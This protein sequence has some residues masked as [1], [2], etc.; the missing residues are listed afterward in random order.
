MN[1]A[2]RRESI[3]S[4]LALAAI[5][6][7]AVVLAATAPPRSIA[8]AC[9]PDRSA[10]PSGVGVNAELEG[11][12]GEEM[13]HQMA[14]IQA[15]GFTWIR[16]RFSWAEAEPEQGNYRWERWEVVLDEAARHN[17]RVIAVLENAPAWAKD[18]KDQMLAGGPPDD[19]GAFASF[20][21]AAA[22]R[23]R[24]R[25]VAYQI[26]D[27]PNLG[28][29]WGSDGVNPA[30]Y[31]ALLSAGY[32]GIKR[33][34]SDAVVLA[35]GLAPTT[36]RSPQNLDDLEFLRG[37]YAAGAQ[38]Y[39]DA[40]AVKPYGFWSGSD[41]PANAGET[42]FARAALHYG[43]MCDNGDGAK[44]IWA[45]EFGWNALPANW[46]G[47]PSPWGSDS[48]AV[49][50]ARSLQAVRMARSEWPWMGP[51]M[52]ASF[53]PQAAADD[54]VWGFALVNPDG[55]ERALAK[56]MGEM[57]ALSY[58]GPGQYDATPTAARWIGDWR[59]SPLGAD[60]GKTGDAVEI[61]FHGTWIDLHL[62][63]GD[64]WATLRVFVDGKPAPDL[65]KDGDGQ[66]YVILYDPE[67]QPRTVTVARGLPDGSHTVRLEAEGGWGQW[68]IA[69]WSVF[70]EASRRFPV[71]LAA[72]IALVLA[73]PIVGSAL[74]WARF[75]HRWILRARRFHGWVFTLGVALGIAL[76][77]IPGAVWLPF[78]GLALIGISAVVRPDI[79]LGT[80]AASLPFYQVYGA[81]LGQG[82]SLTL[83][84]L[85]A[86]ILAAI[87]DRYL[88]WVV[89]GAFGR[90][91]YGLRYAWERAQDRVAGWWR[92]LDGMDF[93]VIALMLVGALSLTASERVGASM[94]EW[95][96][97]VLA[98]GAFYALIHAQKGSRPAWIL[99][100]WLTAG[101][102]AVSVL[103]LI[104]FLTGSNLITAEGVYRVRG[105]YG[106]PN[107]LA[108]FLGRTFPV[109]LCLAAF[110]RRRRWAYALAALPQLLALFLTL[111]RGA[112]LVG[113][114]AALLFIGIVR[115]G[116]TL[117]AMLGVI[118][119]VVAGLI[120]LAGTERIAS[121]FRAGEGTTFLRL[122]LWRS[123]WAMIR[124][125]P[126]RGIGLDNFLYEYR[127]R[128]ILPT[129][130]EERNLSHPHNILLDW[131]TRLGVLG[132]V[133]LAWLLAAF[134]ST[135]ARLYRHLADPTLRA[136][137]LG[138][139]ASMVDF[140][141]HGLVD[142]SFFLTD[143]ALVFAL[144]LGVVAL[145]K[146]EH[147]A[148]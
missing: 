72:I 47:L 52:W 82:A 136:L 123:A 41:D 90:K 62:R 9:L 105:L 112:L 49:Q 121:L 73:F 130:W 74:W 58:S 127:T 46:K 60:I 96:Q 42:N 147:P 59:F 120:P 4:V 54:P 128:Y 93:A 56:A 146:R 38:P 126:L 16:L 84:L 135:A 71:A 44:G 108:L 103:G 3:T 86:T 55:Q 124:D 88:E 75:V 78:A 26:W 95:I 94:R 23:F 144:T 11:L 142:N 45:V 65:P 66:A 24:G 79:A 102:V 5:T 68:A 7:L 131:W 64:Y 67:G 129:A 70:R 39:F 132:L 106:S 91:V 81:I 10:I 122:N 18:A 40:L 99:V 125:H 116:K 36:E 8:P 53:Q 51:M 14:Q 137:A 31:T 61:G 101:A 145:L 119:A 77:L 140:L 27:E 113:L 30:A 19:P 109:A 12:S 97:V 139:M 37:M 89:E 138:L 2:A 29:H 13:D 98:A 48:E 63:P 32:T 141:A 69:G 20:A 17:L 6:I 87:F 21:E 143:L 34:D 25:I 117:W 22:A 85:S 35:G 148:R 43:I 33:G 134:F 133:A 50:D 15:A 57:S 83:A 100:D 1:R 104:Q 80:V 118:A 107:N 114:P 110:G 28:A 92:N 76:F 111:S 115:K